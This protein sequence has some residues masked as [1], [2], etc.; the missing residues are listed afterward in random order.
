[1]I[2]NSEILDRLPPSAIDAECWVIGSILLDPTTID[3]VGWLKPEEFHANA[4]ATIYRTLRAMRDESVIDAGLLL[5]RLRAAGT[6]ESVG[7]A[8]YLAAVAGKVPVSAHAVHYANIVR[9]KARLRAV[10][11]AATEMLRAAYQ[12]GASDELIHTCESRLSRLQTGQYQGEPKEFADT[13]ANV[14][15]RADEVAE[16]HDQLGLPTGFDQYDRDIGGLFAGELVVLAARPRIGKTSLATQWAYNAAIRG[17]LTYFASLEMSDVELVTRLLCGESGVD[18]KRI[19]TGQLDGTDVR[20]LSDAAS[21]MANAHAV[22]DDRP[23][24]TIADMRR[25]C[26]RL[27]KRGLSLIVVD[28]LQRITPID[29]KRSRYEQI[30]EIVQG[31][32]TMARE[33]SVPVVVLAQLSREADKEGRAQ[34]HHLRESGDIEA[35]ADVVAFLLRPVKWDGFDNDKPNPNHA[36]LVVE[37]NRNGDTGTF[38]LSWD[39]SRTRFSTPG[40]VDMPGYDPSLEGGDDGF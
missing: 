29:R 28:Y 4:N 22:I 16:R 7:G 38:R 8:E 14:L 20:R 24:M 34:L 3:R 19:R 35:E 36:V 11:G 17:R 13:L 10:I 9:E 32:K 23:G 21:G 31:L 25:A 5:A 39:G 2:T 40:A 18:N 30:G 37:K 6:L 33:F 12:E 26:R 27:V 15:A 1:M